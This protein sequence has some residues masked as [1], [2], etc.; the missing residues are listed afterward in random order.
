MR[1]S[2]VSDINALYAERRNGR[3]TAERRKQNLVLLSLVGGLATGGLATGGL[4][5]GGFGSEAGPVMLAVLL[6]AGGAVVSGPPPLSTA[7]TLHC[8]LAGTYP[9]P[10]N[11]R[12]AVCISSTVGT[13]GTVCLPTAPPGPHCATCHLTAPPH[14]GTS[15]RHLPP[16]CATSLH[17][18][19]LYLS[20]SCSFSSAP[21]SC[22][23]I[24][25]CSMPTPMNT[26]SWRRSP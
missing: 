10:S 26:I 3:Y 4:A 7:V 6:G 1:T 13:V 22:S 16:H 20:I 18:L 21:S 11:L 8:R 12:V 24:C 17:H 5:T 2:H 25:A 15:L 9:A 14:C 23:H 19:A